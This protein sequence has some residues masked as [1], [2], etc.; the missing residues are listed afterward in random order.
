VLQVQR[1]QPPEDVLTGG[2]PETPLP[3]H[4]RA[5]MMHH[6]QY[7]NQVAVW[8][9][10]NAVRESD[11]N[12]SSHGLT[13]HWKLQGVRLN[14]RQFA[15]HGLDEILAEAWLLVFMPIKSIM[16]VSDSRWA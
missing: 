1:Q 3:P 7:R 4:R 15:F 2:L 5:G 11:R 14:L 6:S 9:I 12:R 16:Q 13:N 8:H 10:E